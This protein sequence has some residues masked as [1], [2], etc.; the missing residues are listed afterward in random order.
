MFYVCTCIFNFFIY[1]YGQLSPIKDLNMYN[2]FLLIQTK[3]ISFLCFQTSNVYGQTSDGFT[4]QTVYNMFQKPEDLDNTKLSTIPPTNPAGD[5]YYIYKFDDCNERK[6]WFADGYTFK[7]MGN[8]IYYPKQTKELKRSRYCIKDHSTSGYNPNFTRTV[9]EMTSL[10]SPCYVLVQY[11]GDQSLYIP[12]SHGNAKNTDKPY[13][14]TAASVRAV[15]KEKVRHDTARTTYIKES[16]RTDVPQ[17]YQGRCN[18]RSQR[19]TDAK[20]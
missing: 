11:L 18:V 6:D 16:M 4:P 9:F 5:T 19:N 13:R 3:K 2:V 14:A 10:Q 17:E 1:V 15:A 7:N 20:Y 8:V 12:R